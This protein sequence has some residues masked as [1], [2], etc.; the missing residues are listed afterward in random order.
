MNNDGHLEIIVA[1]TGQQN[2]V[3]FNQGDGKS[4]QEVRF[5]EASEITYN[6]AVG[7]LNQNGFADI[8]VANSGSRNLVYLNLPV[9]K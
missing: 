6:L 7:D 2:A 4:Y 5:G 9:K 1:N 3:F 8:A